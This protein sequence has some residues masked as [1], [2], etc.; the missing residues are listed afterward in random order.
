MT[1]VR[2]DSPLCS[3]EGLARQVI[4]VPEDKFL[5][6][7]V[8]L[9]KVKSFFEAQSESKAMVIGVDV[10]GFLSRREEG[11][12]FAALSA[13]GFGWTMVTWD[14]KSKFTGLLITRK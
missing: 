6:S 9:E 12:L 3:S 1:H 7:D 10:C 14:P 11:K 2:P 5:Y 8:I 4:E 13:E